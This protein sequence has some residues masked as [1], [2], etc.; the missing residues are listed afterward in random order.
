[1]PHRWRK[2]RRLRWW[3]WAAR[4]PCSWL[5]V[6]GGDPLGD[7]GA[8]LGALHVGG[9]EVEALEHAGVDGVVDDVGERR[10]LAGHLGGVGHDP[11]DAEGD[12]L[13]AEEGVGA[14]IIAADRQ[15]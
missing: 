1:M 4:S 5:E 11:D 13:P 7:V 9:A 2:D 12:R 6:V 3:W 14:C 10:V 15:L 8:D